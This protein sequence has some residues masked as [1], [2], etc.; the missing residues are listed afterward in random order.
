[1]SES[2]FMTY[3]GTFVLYMICATQII[4]PDVHAAL[5]QNTVEGVALVCSYYS[6]Y[7]VC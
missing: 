1:M 7:I 5:V 6:A 2:I 4:L 3:I